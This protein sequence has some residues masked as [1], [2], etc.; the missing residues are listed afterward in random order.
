M[1]QSQL[2]S[3]SP[4]SACE[5]ASRYVLVD[6]FTDTLFSGN[7]LAVFP[8][9]GGLSDAAMQEI[10]RELNLSESVFFLPSDDADAHLRIFT[11]RV[12]LPF[13]GHP[14]L[15]SAAV[16]SWALD[17]EEVRL[18]TGLGLIPVQVSREPRGAAF[19]RMSQPIPSW[20][21]YSRA[22]QL[23]AAVGAGPSRLPVEVYC[24]GP[25]H[26]FVE[27]EDEAAVAALAPDSSA[28]EA[29]GEIGVSCFAGRER[30]WKTRMFGY[31]MGVGEDPAT[32]SAAGPLALHLARHG[33]IRF[34]EEIEIHQGAELERPSVLF[35]R[36]V[37][38]QAEVEKIEVAGSVVLA[39]EGMLRT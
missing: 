24:N 3:F 27:L 12:E 14:V 38:S 6:A 2:R 32:G 16:L 39:G 25:R 15:G 18:L 37:G 34:G 23:L 11:P 19:P 22:A 33:R 35:A 20:E 30:V 4:L 26:V 13:A 28:L 31:G 10:A 7:Q 17:R 8:D 1:S 21:P 36:A 5:Q 9:G 29:L